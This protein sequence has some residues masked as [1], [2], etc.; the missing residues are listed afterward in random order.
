MNRKFVAI[1]VSLIMIFTLA[2]CSALIPDPEPAVTLGTDEDA[3]SPPTDDTQPA[4]GDPV[5]AMS[6]YDSYM[7]I[8]QRLD[9]GPGTDGEFDI[10]FNM[11][12][13][14]SA[15]GESMDFNMGGNIKMIVAGDLMQ[16][17]MT[18]DLSLYGMGEMVMIIDGDNVYASIDG[19]EFDMGISDVMEQIYGSADMPDFGM[20]AIKS[21]RVTQRGSDTVIN[22]VI[23]G[24]TIS[25]FVLSSMDD[26]VAEFGGL[27]MDIYIADVDIEMVLDSADN[28]KSLAM[29]M[30]LVITAEG[31]TI[32]TSVN[33]S[34]VFN[35]LGSG[36]SIVM[37]S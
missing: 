12:F 33:I 2:A 27:D 34:Y 13:R 32:E 8:A 14:I 37:P 18:M 23:D 16:A 20:D 26:L 10:D 21:E 1:L 36:V 22:L 19:L 25:D 3:Q 31:E 5:G 6:A 30:Y 35:H 9:V 7:L 11:D 17:K 4:G 28:P 24:D 29:Y 15:D